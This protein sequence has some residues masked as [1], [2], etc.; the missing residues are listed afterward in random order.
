[1]QTRRDYRQTRPRNASREA[2][3]RR[4]VPWKVLSAI[5]KVIA[6]AVGIAKVIAW[7]MSVDWGSLFG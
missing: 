6:A 5:G 2:R 1:M 3:G 7:L 4:E